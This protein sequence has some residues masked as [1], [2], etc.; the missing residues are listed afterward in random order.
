M[1]RGKPL[2]ERDHSEPLLDLPSGRDTGPV[3]QSSRP[4]PPGVGTATERDIERFGA[5]RVVG[6]FVVTL[7]PG[8]A[9]WWVLMWVIYQPV[10]A[11]PAFLV[12]VT[13]FVAAW[14][15]LP[16]R[17]RGL[18]PILIFLFVF[19]GLVGVF[20]VV[21]VASTFGDLGR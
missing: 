13:V 18:F 14:K 12:V 16:V 2:G 17:F 9:S 8:F 20:V 6:A 19:V 15:L 5:R 3:E 10:W 11:L 21:W 4:F 7:V 1:P